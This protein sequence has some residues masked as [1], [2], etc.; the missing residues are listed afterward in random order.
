MDVKQHYKGDEK[1]KKLI[2][3]SILILLILITSCSSTI[4]NAN[5]NNTP[6]DLEIVEDVNVIEE[7]I[8]LY[9]P[10]FQQI[11]Q[12]GA[13]DIFF[14][15]GYIRFEDKSN[16]N[17]YLY[18]PITDTKYQVPDELVYS[19]FI[20]VNDTVVL[21]YSSSQFSE[22]EYNIIIFTWNY[23]E[24]SISSIEYN[25]II[26][27]KYREF[28]DIKYFNGD[29]FLAFN[30]NTIFRLNK[31]I[32]TYKINDGINFVD[33]PYTFV[34]H[35]NQLYVIA[36][37]DLVYLFDSD[38]NEFIKLSPSP[39]M[40]IEEGVY[41]IENRNSVHTSNEPYSAAFE[42][43]P[44]PEDFSLHY[45]NSYHL[46]DAYKDNYIFIRPFDNLFL[47]ANNKLAEIPIN[48]ETL[49]PYVG[50]I[51]EHRFLYTDD[52]V[53]LYNIDTLEKEEF[54]KDPY[55]IW[56]IINSSS[57]TYFAIQGK[58]GFLSLKFMKK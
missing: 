28:I 56:R 57:E 9:K 24:D 55:Y 5:E 26:N 10:V 2:S 47:Y 36:D 7:P 49:V 12:N 53:F 21:A 58:N 43:P 32:E 34:V 13:K 4:D 37:R 8:D 33:L 52:K 35:N 1:M 6:D 54:L 39:T 22:Y 41:L 14:I 11:T 42:L 45:E 46:S 27:H 17:V 15:D 51:D 16:S 29:I 30:D 31:N 3:L 25:S 18:S 44:I 23:K 19:K 20:H 50:F 48:S 40:V 38:R